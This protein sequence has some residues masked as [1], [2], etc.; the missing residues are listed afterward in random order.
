MANT[1]TITF[2][3]DAGFGAHVDT[4][5]VMWMFD[6]DLNNQAYIH[7]ERGEP[8]DGYYKVMDAKYVNDCMHSVV[9]E[10]T[11]YAANRLNIK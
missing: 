7:K 5:G 1:K 6:Y 10:A 11:P 8:F 9:I 2:V 3:E 4:H